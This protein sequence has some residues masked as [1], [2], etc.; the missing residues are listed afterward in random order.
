M[1]FDSSNTGPNLEGYPCMAS[2]EINDVVYIY[3]MG[4]ATNT[5]TDQFLI[6]DNSTDEWKAGNPINVARR[7]LNDIAAFRFSSVNISKLIA[8]NAPAI[9]AKKPDPQ[10][11]TYRTQRIE[12]PTN[13]ALSG[14]S[15][16]ALDSF[17]TGVCVK[18]YIQS[19]DIK[20]QIAIK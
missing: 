2:Y 12:Y 14:L 17:P 18:R 5:P 13:S 7:M 10:N 9:P 16:T 4:G 20:T 19:M 15:L 6:Y 8:N 1:E 11:D 3:V